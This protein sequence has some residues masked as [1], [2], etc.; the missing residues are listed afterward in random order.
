MFRAA[1]RLIRFK[2]TLKLELSGNSIVGVGG[3]WSHL[4]DFATFLDLYTEL[5]KPFNC[6][7]L[8]HFMY[9]KGKLAKLSGNRTLNRFLVH[10]GA[11]HFH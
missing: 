10:K 5:W 6:Q 1:S 4:A 11:G 2:L 9:T 7:V 3:I 8:F